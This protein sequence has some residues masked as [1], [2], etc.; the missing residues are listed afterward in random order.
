MRVSPAVTKKG[1]I[2]FLHT[3]FNDPGREILFKRRHSILQNI[4]EV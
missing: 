3:I 2:N 4:K 1:L